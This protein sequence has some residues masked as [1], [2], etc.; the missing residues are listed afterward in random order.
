M[1]YKNAMITGA[2]RGIGRAIAYALAG[3]GI[4][5]FLVAR[6]LAALEETAA[7]CRS[8][9]SI[10]VSHASNISDPATI[11]NLVNN[12][13]DQLGDIDILVNCAGLCPNDGIEQVTE[14]E[15]DE[16]MGVNLKALF[17]LS[18]NVLS[19]MKKN[20]CGYIININSTVAFG[21]KPSVTVYSASKYAVTGISA[22]LYED[23]KPFGVKV[24]SVYPGVTDTEML[25]SQEPFCP[26]DLWM[27]PEDIA[28]CVTFLLESS[29]RMMIKD[30]VPWAFGYDKI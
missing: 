8:C 6:N 27:K 24:S 22:A 15:W 16:V 28:S 26:P 3:R 2:G 23:A 4:N 1:K 21:A 5:T 14:Q 19:H 11:P 29:S 17:F 10:S 25:R 20:R 18:Q 13:I 30:I 12:A 9:G 7:L